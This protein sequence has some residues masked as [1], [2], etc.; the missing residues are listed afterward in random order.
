LQTA[1]SLA[2]WLNYYILSLQSALLSQRFIDV[3][4]MMGFLRRTYYPNEQETKYVSIYL[5]N[6][7]LK[8]I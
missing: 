2:H 3:F 1:Y 5:K 6:D 8:I 7:D 4:Q